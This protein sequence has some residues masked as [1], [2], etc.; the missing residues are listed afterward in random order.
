MLF[1]LKKP[2]AAGEYV[3]FELTFKTGKTEFKQKIKVQI[4]VSAD[5]QSDDH[6]H[7]HH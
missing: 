4:K 7:H 3:N 5:V 1:D 6:S 2:L